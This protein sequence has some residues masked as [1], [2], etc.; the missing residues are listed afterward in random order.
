[1]RRV[2]HCSPGGAPHF[3]HAIESDSRKSSSLSTGNLVPLRHRTEADVAQQVEQ[4]EME[5]ATVDVDKTAQNGIETLAERYRSQPGAYRPSAQVFR[6]GDSG[7][8]GSWVA[9]IPC[10]DLCDAHRWIAQHTYGGPGSYD[11]ALLAAHSGRRANAARVRVDAD[12]RHAQQQPTPS[13][14]PAIAAAATA[15]QESVLERLVAALVD[16]ERDRDRRPTEPTIPWAQ[17]QAQIDAAREEARKAWSRGYDEGRAFGHRLGVLEAAAKTKP[18]ESWTPGDVREMVRDIH[19]M[20]RAPRATT[21]DGT[22][23]VESVLEAAAATGATPDQVIAFA[24]AMLGTAT[25]QAISST[26]GT[27]VEEIRRS[28]H[29]LAAWLTDEVAAQIGRRLSEV[30]A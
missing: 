17:A 8:Q 1:M 20:L 19:G 14:Q 9:D 12:M 18:S 5:N 2:R 4:L 6:V 28:G 27:I 23:T 13:A 22:T 16:R 25:V 11:I 30:R 10:A 26:W 29:P 7:R 21:A 24:R 15:Q 3:G